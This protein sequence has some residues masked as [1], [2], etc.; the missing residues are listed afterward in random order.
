MASKPVD[1]P[2]ASPK[3]SPSRIAKRTPTPRTPL[4]TPSPR[5]DTSN[6]KSKIGS[7]DKTKHTP[8]GG[9]NF[10]SAI[11]SCLAIII[12]KTYFKEVLLVINLK[13]WHD[14]SV[15]RCIMIRHVSILG[16]TFYSMKKWGFL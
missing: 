1:S 6:V 16:D 9:N 8:G 3:A 5:P 10:V 2:K 7:L 14:V 12:S 4:S 11:D 13:G 15:N